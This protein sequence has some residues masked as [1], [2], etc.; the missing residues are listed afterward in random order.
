MKA[1]TISYKR[2]PIIYWDE[3]EPGEKKEL[4][5]EFQDNYPEIVHDAFIRFNGSTMSLSEFPIIPEN[6]GKGVFY[7]KAGKAISAFSGYLLYFDDKFSD[8]LLITLY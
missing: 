7:P 5:D 2:T 4:L 6:M 1:K 3:L 8:T